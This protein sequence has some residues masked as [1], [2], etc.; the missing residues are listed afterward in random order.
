MKIA[1][2][3]REVNQQIVEMG[4]RFDPNGELEARFLCECGCLSWV[5]M[6]AKKYADGGAWVQGH[7]R[8]CRLARPRSTDVGCRSCG[9]DQVGVE[10]D[11]LDATDADHA[12]ES[13]VRRLGVSSDSALTP[14]VENASL[15]EEA[16]CEDASMWI[17]RAAAGSAPDQG[18][19][20][21]GMH[22]GDAKPQP[23]DAVAAGRE[24]AEAVL[25]QGARWRPVEHSSCCTSQGDEVDDDPAAIVAK[26]PQRNRLEDADALTRTSDRTGKHRRDCGL[27][28]RHHA[29]SREHHGGE[30]PTPHIL[31]TSPTASWFR[32]TP[33]APAA[34][35]TLARA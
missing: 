1:D 25:R 15:G 4:A 12:R 19:I 6:P 31:S 20:G 16:A 24:L 27:S 14:N 3:S 26:P 32:L 17:R 22:S 21:A 5:V 35:G 28:A 10:A 23:R 2:V 18:C 30:K 29:N 34:F 7:A 13:S 8:L 11:A 9:D 33:I